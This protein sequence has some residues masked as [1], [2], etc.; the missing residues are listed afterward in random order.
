MSLTII[1]PGLSFKRNDESTVETSMRMVLLKSWA[2]ISGCESE[3]AEPGRTAAVSPPGCETAAIA[4][5]ISPRF[6]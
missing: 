6:D 5:D 1:Y 4:R 2:G 3:P